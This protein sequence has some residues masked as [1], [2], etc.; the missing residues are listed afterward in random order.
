L[1]AEYALTAIP[2]VVIHTEDGAP[3]ASDDP[4]YV[5]WLAAGGVPDP[6][7][8]PPITTTGDPSGNPHVRLDS[9]VTTAVDVWN[10]NTPQAAPGGGQG[11]MSV[12]ER[13]L[14]LEETVREKSRAQGLS[15]GATVTMKR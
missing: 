5:A 4:E 8:P 10:A 6:F 3:V 7:V 9:G 1:T 15:T 13:L 14:R 11:G 12:E 2:E